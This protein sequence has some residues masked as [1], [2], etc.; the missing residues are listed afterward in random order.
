MKNAVSK[1]QKMFT[2][3]LVGALTSTGVTAVAL[4][5]NQSATQNSPMSQDMPG[6]PGMSDSSASPNTVDGA[7]HPELI[8]D[9][10]AEFMYFLA[11]ATDK[12]SNEISL[13]QQYAHLHFGAGLSDAEVVAVALVLTDFKTKFTA[14][15]DEYNATQYSNDATVRATGLT[16]FL[17]K[18]DALVQATDGTLTGTLSSNGAAKLHSHI[19]KEKSNMKIGIE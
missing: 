15:S 7:V 19:M 17:A 8:P 10:K 1:K 13:K 11:L 4:K 5:R 18:R 9:N 2:L 16:V 3:L 14:I 6:M 12:G